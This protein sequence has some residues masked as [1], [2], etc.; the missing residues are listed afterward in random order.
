M[1]SLAFIACFLS[2]FAITLNLFWIALFFNQISN[3]WKVFDVEINEI[4]LNGILQWKEVKSIPLNVRKNIRDNFQEFVKRNSRSSYNIPPQTIKYNNNNNN[5]EQQQPDE[6]YLITQNIPPNEYYNMNNNNDYTSFTTQKMKYFSS[7]LPFE[8]HVLS[9]VVR[10]V[11]NENSCSCLNVPNPCKKGLPGPPG[12]KGYN[13]SDGVPG[14]NGKPGIHATSSI[15]MCMSSQS[16]CIS[17]PIGKQGLP[18]S[19]GKRGLRGLKGVNGSSGCPGKHGIPGI[20]G[21]QGDNGPGGPPGIDG[22][23]GP[24]GNDGYAMKANPGLPGPKGPPGI[25]GLQGDDGDQGTPGKPGDIGIVGMPGLP[26]NPGMVGIDGEPGDIGNDGSPGQYCPCPKKSNEKNN[27]NIESISP[28]SQSNLNTNTQGLRGEIDQINVPN[29]QNNNYGRTII[30]ERITNIS[31]VQSIPYVNSQNTMNQTIHYGTRSENNKPLDETIGSERIV[32]NNYE[33]EDVNSNTNITQI[34]NQAVYIPG[35]NTPI[36][37]NIHKGNVKNQTIIEENYEIY[38]THHNNENPN[39]NKNVPQS[40]TEVNHHQVYYGPNNANT[41]RNQTVIEEHFKIQNNNGDYVYQN[42]NNENSNRNGEQIHQESNGSGPNIINT[43]QNQTIIHENFGPQNNGYSQQ[44]YNNENPN[45]NGQQTHKEDNTGNI[46][47]IMSTITNQTIINENVKAQNPYYSYSQQNNNNP[48][49]PKNEAQ[50]EVKENNHQNNYNPNGINIIRNQTIIQE[51]YRIQNSNNDNSQQNTNN[52]YLGQNNEG[53]NK[54]VEQAHV[55]VDYGHNTQNMNTKGEYIPSRIQIITKESYDSS[56][57]NNDNLKKAIITPSEQT[58]ERKLEN[59][60]SN[61]DNNSFS[62]NPTYENDFIKGSGLINNKP[63][64]TETNNDQ[65]MIKKT[66]ITQIT[67]E[68]SLPNQEQ[69]VKFTENNN[70]PPE[71]QSQTGYSKITLSGYEIKNSKENVNDAPLPS[72]FPMAKRIDNVVHP[73]A[74]PEPDT[75]VYSKGNSQESSKNVKSLNEYINKN[76]SFLEQEIQPSQIKYEQMNGYERDFVSEVIPVIKKD[77]GIQ[78]SGKQK[79]INQYEAIKI[80]ELPSKEFIKISEESKIITT[81][82]S[83]SIKDIH[84]ISTTFFDKSSVERSEVNTGFIPNTEPLLK[85]DD[86]IASEKDS[87][88]IIN[89]ISIIKS[90]VDKKNDIKELGPK[91][92]LDK[93][94][95]SLKKPGNVDGYAKK[96]IK[97]D[98]VFGNM[99]HE[100]QVSERARDSVTSKN[101]L[102]KN[103]DNEYE[104]YK[105]VKKEQNGDNLHININGP[106]KIFIKAK[107]SSESLGDNTG[108]SKLIDKEGNIDGYELYTSLRRD[109]PEIQGTMIEILTPK[110]VFINENGTLLNLKNSSKV[111]SENLMIKNVEDITKNNISSDVHSNSGKEV[112]LKNI[113]TSILTTNLNKVKEIKK[114]L[115][116]NGS[117]KTASLINKIQIIK[118]SNKTVPATENILNEASMTMSNVVPKYNNEKEKFKNLTFNINEGNT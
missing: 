109:H 65:T 115:Y 10:I 78:E 22:V 67:N 37:D 69:K 4:K 52:D 56:N 21:E 85:Q 77:S 96:V 80:S 43:T 111:S 13:G 5:Y 106:N 7:K 79:V 92:R 103:I 95:I 75:L 93:V 36:D 33:G 26:G 42:N 47:N 84:H 48:T 117:T 72:Q 45:K 90:N 62:Q 57:N 110:K 30:N 51:N 74:I 82:K 59:K 88:S 91:I 31:Q 25:Q 105:N 87:D 16:F 71:F 81:T 23:Q 58:N 39:M 27:V 17:C 18:G 29:T 2:I 49:L 102:G 76:N 40:H 107:D 112:K 108:H 104:L 44:I 60:K 66:I 61:E 6:S 9:K 70:I 15:D 97:I 8:G 113:S 63:H 73:P 35:S 20:P 14:T 19:Q 100:E 12:K 50:F 28:I 11:N 116:K 24:P 98:K 38:N 41:V 53:S 32:N 46:P 118:T 3:S 1:F 34:N 68:G 89:K 94:A 83:P 64:N 101:L 54:N 55:E 99:S 114:P 86:N